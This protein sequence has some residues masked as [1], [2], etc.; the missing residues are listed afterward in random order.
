LRARI[1][2][3]LLNKG[4]SVPFH[5]QFLIASFIESL[6]QRSLH[7]FPGGPAH[8]HFSGLKGQI[9]VGK[10]GLYFYSSK[11]TLVFASPNQTFMDQ[12]L[13]KLFQL[14]Q[15]E[16]GKLQLTPLQVEKEEMPE[17][18]DEMKFLCISPMVIMHPLDTED[19]PKKFISPSADVFSDFLYEEIMLRMESAGYTPEQLEKFFKFQ[20][21]PDK[22]YLSKIKDGD[23]KF[24]RV[25][26]VF[27]EG[28]KHEVRGYT[29][30]FTLYADKEVQK[31]VLSNGLGYLTEKG[32]GMLDIA[33]SDPNLRSVPYPVNT[34]RG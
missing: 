32:F 7:D 4:A 14:P 28:E 9:K 12:F 18:Q 24:A 1:I 11:I 20:I 33:N 10:D 6:I 29:L 31:F 8:Y 21:V 16:I 2:F 22:E 17:L 5:H 27:L 13:S 15:I 34:S 19:D 3:G 25:F 30:P 23:K 26:P